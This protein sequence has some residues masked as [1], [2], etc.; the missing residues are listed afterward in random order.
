MDG[1]KQCPGTISCHE[2]MSSTHKAKTKKSHYIVM[3]HVVSCF[4]LI[5]LDFICIKGIEDLPVKSSHY[6]DAV[7]CL[8]VCRVTKASNP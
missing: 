1:R 4:C 3:I 8:K 5:M 6:L 2:V 7:G